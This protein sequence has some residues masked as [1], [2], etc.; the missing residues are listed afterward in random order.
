[1]FATFKNN[2][3]TV[4]R[5]VNN[6]KNNR[7]IKKTDNPIGNGQKTLQAL[8]K[9]GDPNNQSIYEKKCSISIVISHMQ[10]TLLPT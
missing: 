10:I 4:L 7:K 9:R 3:D 8:Y 1:M 5:S 6:S 2:K